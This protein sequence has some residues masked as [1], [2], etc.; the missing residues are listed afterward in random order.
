MFSWMMLAHVKFVKMC[1]NTKCQSEVFLVKRFL[2]LLVLLLTMIYPKKKTLNVAFEEF[3][4]AILLIY[5]VFFGPNVSNCEVLS[6]Y[7]AS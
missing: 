7:K 5:T 6:F 1:S 4:G 2:W 3:V